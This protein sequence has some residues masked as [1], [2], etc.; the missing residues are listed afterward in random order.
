MFHTPCHPVQGN[1]PWSRVVLE[2]PT[3]FQLVKKFPAFY[4]TWSFL[5]AFTSARHFL[6]IHLNIFLPSTPGS[7]KWSLSLRPPLPKTLYT[8]DL[9]RTRYVPR[10]SYSRFLLPEQYWVSNTDHA[11]L[12]MQLP[13]I[14]CLLVPHRP[15][16][17][18]QHPLLRHPQPAFL[19]VSDQVSHPYRTT[20][21][22]IVLYSLT[23]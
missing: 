20:G 14:P 10:P 19:S 11:A 3:G 17:F 9:P 15:K 5:A 8:C 4:G 21:R 16:Y 2:K 18:P 7:P 13:P 23:L 12:I 6:K 1:T 22:V